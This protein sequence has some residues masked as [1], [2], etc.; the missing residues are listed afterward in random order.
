MKKIYNISIGQLITMWVFGGIGW[1]FSA[2]WADGGPAISFFLIIL[3]PFFL[4][5]YTIGWLNNRN[6]Q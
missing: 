1:F 3:I 5:F 4:I 2:I 6:K